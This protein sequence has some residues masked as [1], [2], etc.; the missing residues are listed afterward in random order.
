VFLNRGDHPWNPRDCFELRTFL[1]EPHQHRELVEIFTAEVSACPHLERIALI[2]VTAAN[3]LAHRGAEFGDIAAA[4]AELMRALRL[5][6]QTETLDTVLS[7]K[8]PGCIRLFRCV[9][10]TIFVLAITPAGSTTLGMAHLELESLT[11]SLT[12]CLKK[13]VGG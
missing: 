6:A 5:L 7:T 3:I 4:S 11:E 9:S 10:D 8:S 2:H 13:P 1:I 12:R